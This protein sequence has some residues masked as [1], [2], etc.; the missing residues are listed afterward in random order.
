M[1]IR[2]PSPNHN[3]RTAT[4]AARDKALAL[5]LCLSFVRTSAL[6]SPEATCP[7]HRSNAVFLT[8]GAIITDHTSTIGR[9]TAV[10]IVIV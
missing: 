2:D 3:E 8:K 9:G 4:V 5:S 1:K 6:T 10:D 7:V